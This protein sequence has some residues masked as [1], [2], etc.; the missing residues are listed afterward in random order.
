MIGRVKFYLRGERNKSI[1]KLRK[2]LMDS[3]ILLLLACNCRWFDTMFSYIHE[4]KRFAVGSHSLSQW[5]NIFSRKEAKKK[6]KKKINI[7]TF[8]FYFS[9]Q[10]FIL[11]S[12]PIFFDN[13]Q[14]NPCHLISSRKNQ[15]QNI[16]THFQ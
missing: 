14:L 2:R 15:C 16:N 10:R 6:K 3:C 8:Y 7:L 1:G 13:T 9:S 5:E 4:C 12:F 11:K